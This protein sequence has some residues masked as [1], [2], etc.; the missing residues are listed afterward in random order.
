MRMPPS[1]DTTSPA[2][3]S[4]YSALVNTQVSSATRVR[5]IATCYIPFRYYLARVG[6]KKPIIPQLVKE[7]NGGTDFKETNGECA[8]E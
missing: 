2:F 7:G 1:E 4:A 5:V 8:L 3:T 6:V